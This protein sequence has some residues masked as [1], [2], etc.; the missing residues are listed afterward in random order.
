ML[1][2]EFQEDMPLQMYVF[3]VN[4]QAKLADVFV[5]FLAVPQKPAFVSPA[6]I[7]ARRETWLQAWTGLV[8]R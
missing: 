8:L 4:P 3:P 2:V 6:D 1:S 7:T 5:K